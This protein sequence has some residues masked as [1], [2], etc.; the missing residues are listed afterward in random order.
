M[1]EFFETFDEA[2]RPRGLVP[3]REVH[4]RGLWHR[5]VHVFLFRPDG[6]LWIQQR[7][8]DKDIYPGRWDLTVGEHLQ[9]GEDYAA[10]AH[11]GLREE[12]GIDAVD[13]TPLGTEQRFRCDL[14]GRGIADHEL[15]AAFHGV[16]DGPLEPDGVEVT[17]VRPIGAAQLHAWIARAA[18]AF[19]PWFLHELRT[20]P[21]LGAFRLAGP[22]EDDAAAP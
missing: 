15:Q 11:R 21:G 9:P 20:R 7:A 12:L 16:F 5:S 18:D 8:P 3:R 2:G 10:A 13:L 4:A 1:T 19:T 22:E 14:P 17:A 6:T